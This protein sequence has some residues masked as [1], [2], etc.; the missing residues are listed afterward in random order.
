MSLLKETLVRM[1]RSSENPAVLLKHKNTGSPVFGEQN[2]RDRGLRMGE[3]SRRHARGDS[4]MLKRI[5]ARQDPCGAPASSLNL[6]SREEPRMLPQVFV[7]RD[8]KKLRIL[9]GNPKWASMAWI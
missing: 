1:S 8:P 5:P 2:P 7:C 4:D 6:L 9:S 3:F